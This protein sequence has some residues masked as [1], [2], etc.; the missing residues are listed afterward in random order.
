MSHINTLKSHF[1][2]DLMI[3]IVNKGHKGVL[4]SYENIN[5]KKRN[6]MT[7]VL[8]ALRLK[9]YFGHLVVRIFYDYATGE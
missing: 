1:V 5:N 9:T 3:Y 4:V 6:F 2:A 8:K 7:V